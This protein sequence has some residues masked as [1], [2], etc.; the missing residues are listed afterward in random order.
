MSSWRDWSSTARTSAST[1]N[2]R[3]S[4]VRATSSIPAIDRVALASQLGVPVYK[5]ET[6]EALARQLSGEGLPADRFVHEIQTYNEACR[7]GSGDGLSPPR[8]RHAIPV[9]KPPL[10]AVRCVPG[11]T[12]TTGGVAVDDRGRVLDGEKRP[13]PGLYA[14]GADAG[15]IFG[16]HY[17]GFLGWALVSGRL[18]GIGAAAGS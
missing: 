6:L 14:A 9:E 3:H 18:C 11:I 17:A 7:S 13:I 1:A 5:A 8:I 16:R 4:H 12:C 10:Y 2:A 15:G